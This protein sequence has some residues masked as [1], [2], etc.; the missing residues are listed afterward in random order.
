MALPQQAAQKEKQ[1][2]VTAADKIQQKPHP[3]DI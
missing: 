1:K 3:A 2:M